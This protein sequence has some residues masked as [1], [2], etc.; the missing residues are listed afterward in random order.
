MLNRKLQRNQLIIQQKELRL[1]K[2]SVFSMKSSTDIKMAFGTTIMHSKGGL[3]ITLMIR[4]SMM[5]HILRE[6]FLRLR[7]Y[8]QQD[9]ETNKMLGQLSETETP[10]L[11]LWQSY[12]PSS[13]RTIQRIKNKFEQKIEQKS[14]TGLTIS[15]HSVTTLNE[16]L[17]SAALKNLTLF[18]YFMSIHFT[19][20][21][22]LNIHLINFYSSF[23]FLFPSQALTHKQG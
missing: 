9:K 11:I 8:I 21:M 16:S 1:Q 13:D 15:Y 7:H 17:A 22:K 3:T 14:T 18:T 5:T 23:F 19:I 12:Y 10:S 20:F 2:K 4:I 6:K